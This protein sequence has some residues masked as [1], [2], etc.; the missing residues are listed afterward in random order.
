MNDQKPYPL[1][2]CPDVQ[3]VANWSSNELT[4]TLTFSDP[5]FKP[6][7]FITKPI[8]R[9]GLIR[10]VTYLTHDDMVIGTRFVS[11]FYLANPL[12]ARDL[13]QGLEIKSPT[14]V[15][16][17]P[18]KSCDDDNYKKGFFFKVR[19][20][21]GVHKP[22]YPDTEIEKDTYRQIVE[23]CFN[24]FHAL[25]GGFIT[26]EEA[27]NCKWL[28]DVKMLSFTAEFNGIFSNIDKKNLPP[29]VRLVAYYDILDTPALY[30]ECSFARSVFLWAAQGYT[31]EMI[32]FFMGVSASKIS[33]ILN[34][35]LDE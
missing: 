16:C 28:I 3:A 12:T 25:K 27:G 2:L 20:A 32:A 30:D 6:V 33:R 35:P 7:H 24:L 26:P 4:G 31:Q 18:K 21:I 22:H 9:H 1:P 10:E 34:Q 19:K 8:D 11:R 17:C 29:H 13:L 23:Q 14:S 15:R 5:A